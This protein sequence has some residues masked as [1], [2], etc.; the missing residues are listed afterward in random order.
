MA[1]A[2]SLTVGATHPVGAAEAP[3]VV[4]RAVAFSVRNVNDSAVPCITDGGTE[5]IAGRLVGPRRAF[6][7]API[8]AATV[9]L[10]AATTTSTLW[11]LPLPGYDYAT[12]LARSG[13]VSVVLDQLGYGESSR[14]PGTGICLGGE[15]SVVHQVIAQLRSGAYSTSTGGAAPV[16][17][18]MI[19]G[20]SI[21]GAV[22][23]AEAY[24]YHD[25]AGL[26]VLSW[27]DEPLS[28][29]VQAKVSVRIAQICGR[30]GDGTAPG[31]YLYNWP[32]GSDE[33]RDLVVTRDPDVIRTFEA[34]IVPDPCGLDVSNPQTVARDNTLV[35]TITVPVAVVGGEEDA[36]VPPSATAAQRLRFTGT[37]DVSVILMP[38]AGHLL[39]LERSA[40][41]LQQRLGSWLAAHGA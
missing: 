16:R 14:P 13:H 11:E 17:R 2:A 24:S 35:P 19:A 5:V 29:S 27:A 9:Y 31:G 21:S 41:Q 36:V 28:P 7:G 4:Q 6:S 18:I 26:V 39:P 40:A 23:E 10:H 20:I 25:V 30:G 33:V 15:A 34:S 38:N 37:G 8:A 12:A 1:L 32:S 3:P 22:A